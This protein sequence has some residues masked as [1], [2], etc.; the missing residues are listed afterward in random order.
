MERIEKLPWEI[1]IWN[2]YSLFEMQK[3]KWLYR[4]LYKPYII[5]R[6]EFTT[7]NEAI[8]NTILELKRQWY[9]LLSE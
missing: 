2:R 1:I 8:D 7:L 5:E 3:R 9:E 4:I 6:A